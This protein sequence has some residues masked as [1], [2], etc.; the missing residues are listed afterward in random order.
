[1]HRH[2][3]SSAERLCHIEYMF[4]SGADPVVFRQVYPTDST[5]RIHQELG[6]SCDVLTVDCRAHVKQVVTTNYIRTRIRKKCE[7]VL[8]LLTKLARDLGTVY[9]D[10]NRTNPCLMKF[11]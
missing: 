8:G 5:G 3:G 2:D 4:R 11:R 9:A 7:C 10:R 1:M 6:R